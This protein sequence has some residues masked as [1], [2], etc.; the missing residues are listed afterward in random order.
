MEQSHIFLMITVLYSSKIVHAQN[1]ACYDLDNAWSCYSWFLS[2]LCT[3]RT[4]YNYM[5]KNCRKTCNLCPVIETKRPAEKVK[6]DGTVCKDN[7]N[8]CLQWRIHCGES[9]EYFDFMTKHCQRSCKFCVDKNC[10]DKNKNCEKYEQVGYCDLDHKY[11]RFMNKTCPKACGFCLPKDKRNEPMRVNLYLPKKYHCNFTKHT[12]E[13]ENVHFEDGAD[14]KIGLVQYGPQSGFNS[15]KGS[16]LYLDTRLEGYDAKLWLPWILVLPK[17]EKRG[18][19]CLRFMY[20]L[21]GGTLS[22]I[23]NE[24]PTLARKFPQRQILFRTK[25]PTSAWEA[26]NVLIQATDSNYLLL[27]GLKGR[28]STF[29]IIDELYFTEGVC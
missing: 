10:A 22:V 27:V 21:S 6:V 25:I 23:Q 20:Q 1:G 28:P 24:S 29:I 12:C 7:R 5:Y 15:T 16:Y 14:W 4:Y 17:D 11:F 2:G 3:E 8:K 19:M 13:W 18:S 26:A 9:S